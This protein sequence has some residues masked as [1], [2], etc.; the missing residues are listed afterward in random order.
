MNGCTSGIKFVGERGH[1]NYI[2]INICG[3]NG[4]SLN[5]HKFLQNINKRTNERKPE[6]NKKK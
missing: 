1:M 3:Y 6:M 2:N 4:N 5:F